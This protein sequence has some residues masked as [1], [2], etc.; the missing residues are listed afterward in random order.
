M[1]AIYIHLRH[2][3]TED[4]NFLLA[5]KPR[6][7]STASIPTEAAVGMRMENGDERG[8]LQQLHRL[9]ADQILFR[10]RLG[11]QAACRD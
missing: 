7:V 5:P 11:R 9:C 2:L 4:C 1:M 3:P 10:L 8:S 6:S